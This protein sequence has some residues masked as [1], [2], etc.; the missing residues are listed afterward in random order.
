MNQEGQGGGK[1]ETRS[2]TGGGA[3]IIFPSI[4]LY[5]MAPLPL[6]DHPTFPYPPDKGKKGKGVEFRGWGDLRG[7]KDEI[8]ER[9]G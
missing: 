5:L 2:G 1:G 9:G 3:L 6:F 7:R 4:A 8:G